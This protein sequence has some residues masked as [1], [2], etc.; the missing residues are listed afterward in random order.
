MTEDCSRGFTVLLHELTTALGVSD[1]TEHMWLCSCAH[2]G[3]ILF[4]YPNVSMGAR[5][6]GLTLH[7]A[8]DFGKAILIRIGFRVIF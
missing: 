5:R 8:D 4:V 6:F 1:V 3:P 2:E 7:L